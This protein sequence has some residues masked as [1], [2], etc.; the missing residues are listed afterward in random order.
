MFVGM[1]TFC[2]VL[3]YGELGECR[4][5]ELVVTETREECEFAVDFVVMTSPE[6]EAIAELMLM[7]NPDAIDVE[8][9]W[10]C[11]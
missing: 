7:Q 2:T 10:G 6:V 11:I 5:V 4:N 8:W 9:T 1:I 3:M